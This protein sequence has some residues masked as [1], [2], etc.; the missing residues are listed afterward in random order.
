LYA[1]VFESIK[2]L[3]KEVDLLSEKLAS[4]NPEALN[5]MKKVLWKNTEHWDRLLIE[6]AEVSG[7]LV[8]SDFTKK[9]LQ[10]LKK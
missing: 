3:D 5:Q 8:L 10:K 1:K 4:Y 9:A 7:E 2:E 6:R